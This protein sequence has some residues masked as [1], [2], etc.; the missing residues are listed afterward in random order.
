MERTA[1]LELSK[2]GLKFSIWTNL[3]MNPHNVFNSHM[4]LSEFLKPAYPQF[5]SSLKLKESIEQNPHL[6]VLIE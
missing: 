1:A 5:C 6:T 3:G 4:T 2:P